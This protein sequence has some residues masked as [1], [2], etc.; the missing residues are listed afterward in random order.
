MDV[1][2]EFARNKRELVSFV[3]SDF[4]SNRDKRKSLTGYLFS[5][6]GCAVNWKSTLQVIV[7]LSTTEAEYMALA[8]AIKEAIWLKTLFTELDQEQD[9]IVVHCH[10]QS[11]IHLSNDQMFHERTNHIDVRYHFIHEVIACGEIQVMKIGTADNP[12]DM[13]T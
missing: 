9:D 11:A 10:S 5:I 12:T 8:E 4:A 7:A 1:R 2:L 3:D 13:M 6:E